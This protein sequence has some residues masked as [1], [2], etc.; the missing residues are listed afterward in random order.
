MSEVGGQKV[1]ARIRIQEQGLRLRN[2]DKGER[3]KERGKSREK[4]SAVGGSGLE[5]GIISEISGT[6]AGNP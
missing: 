4:R 6:E 3:R 5:I 2:K 1:R